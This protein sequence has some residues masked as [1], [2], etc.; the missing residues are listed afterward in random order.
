MK[1][2]LEVTEKLYNIDFVSTYGQTAKVRT[3]HCPLFSKRQEEPKMY[4]SLQENLE[5]K[6][7]VREKL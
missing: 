4:L 1:R 3:V 2:T 5:S 7:H 6:R